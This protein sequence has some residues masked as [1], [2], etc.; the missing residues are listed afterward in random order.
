[1]S[2]RGVQ[3]PS[4]TGQISLLR[5]LEQGLSLAMVSRGLLLADCLDVLER[6]KIKL[7]ADG[8]GALHGLLGGRAASI[9]P[10]CETLAYRRLPRLWLAVTVRFDLPSC[11]VLDVVRRS[12]NVEFYSPAIDLPKQFEVPV[13]WP[14][15]T[16][17]KGDG[18][19]AARTLALLAEPLAELFADVRVKE[20]LIARR[21]VRIVYQAR[22]GFHD[23]YLLL[24]QS[25][26]DVERLRPEEIEPLITFVQGI[27]DQLVS[28]LELEKKPHASAI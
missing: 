26:F 25:R 23:A 11:G 10:F 2:D 24:R 7:M 12:T 3:D 14:Q 27:A 19:Q 17:I 9:T 15:D 16:L 18:A 1:M 4:S 21:G 6:G 22:Q 8:W 20:V 13:Q 5:R 28:P